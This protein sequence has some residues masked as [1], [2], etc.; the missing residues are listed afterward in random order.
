M[1]RIFVELSEG[2]E[3]DSKFPLIKEALTKARISMKIQFI[4]LLFRQ[5]RQSTRCVPTL[6]TFVSIPTAIRLF[7]ATLRLRISMLSADSSWR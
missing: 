2:H 4:P 1:A 7:C 6:W 3:I 5:Q